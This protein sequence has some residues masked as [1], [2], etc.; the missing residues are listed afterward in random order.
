LLEL[1]DRKEGVDRTPFAGV[2]RI[3]LGM[4]LRR[5]AIAKQRDG[6]S[7]SKGLISIPA[8]TWLEPL[9]QRREA[10]TGYPWR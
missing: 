7:G 9:Q 10:T 3:R 6:G 5:T 1:R 4:L 2:N 8:F